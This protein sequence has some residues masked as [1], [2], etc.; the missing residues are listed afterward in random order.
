M[1]KLVKG[2]L[3]DVVVETILKQYNNESPFRPGGPP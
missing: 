1:Y 3:R 2:N